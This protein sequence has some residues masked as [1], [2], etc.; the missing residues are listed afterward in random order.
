MLSIVSPPYP[1][2]IAHVLH[3]FLYLALVWILNVCC[4]SCQGVG[5]WK[6]PRTPW[7][8]Y[9]KFPS[10]S[11][12]FQ[13][14]KS[15]IYGKMYAKLRKFDLIILKFLEIIV[16]RTK[17]SLNYFFLFCVRNNC[18]KQLLFSSGIT[19]CGN[20]CWGREET[21]SPIAQNAQIS[22]QQLEAFNDSLSS[23]FW[24]YFKIYS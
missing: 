12:K 17:N 4:H 8:I 18:T 7:K 22:N 16:I 5:N 9:E 2:D 14:E 6:I 3:F 15:Y 11:G 23:L 13:A 1:T 10:I 24:N 19:C 21:R 20:Q